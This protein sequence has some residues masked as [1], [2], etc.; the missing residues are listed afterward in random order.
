MFSKN[1]TKFLLFGLFILNLISFTIPIQNPSFLDSNHF[2]ANILKDSGTEQSNSVVYQTVPRLSKSASSNLQKDLI[3]STNIQF[4]KS[5]YYTSGWADTRWKFRKNITISASKVSSDLTNFPVYID[6]FDTDLQQDAQ[7]SGNDIL[8]TNASGDLLDHEIEIYDRVYNSSHSH[9][10]AWVKT[11]LSSS[12]DT[13]ISMYYGN[14]T[15]INQENPSA[16]WDENYEFVLHMNQDP[17]SSDILDSTSNN[18]DFNVE[19]TGSMTSDDLVYGQTGHALTFDGND[20]FIYLP[21]SEGFI[22]PTSAMTFEFWIMFPNGGPG[23]RDF[24]AVPATSGGD[25]RLSF[26]DEFEFHIETTTDTD[27]VTSNQ[28]SFSANTWYHFVGLWN[29]SG[30][31]IHQI[32]LGGSLDGF[33][34][35]PLS[36]T[37]ISWNTL[38][39]GT[40]DDSSDG[41]GGNADGDRFLHATLSEFRLSNTIRSAT[42]IATEFEN[43]N[44]TQTFYSISSEE[45]YSS[46]KEWHYTGLKFRKEIVIDANKVS[47]SGTLTNFP[48]LINLYDTDLHHPNNVQTDGDDILFCDAS[49]T[50]LDHEIELFDQNYDGT[51][52]HLIA[53]VEIPSLSGTD[54]TSI[55]MYFGNEGL[56]SQANSEG[57]W[58][59]NYVGVWHL[60]QDPSGTPPQIEDSTSP[61]TDGTVYGSMTSNDLVSGVI[62]EALNFDGTEDFIDFGNPTEM[63]ITGA[64]TVETWFWS[65]NGDQNEYI[66]GKNGPGPDMR[67]WDLSFDPINNTHGYL[68]FRYDDD[69]VLPHYGEVS[70]VIYEAGQWHHVTGVYYPSTYLR[71]Y[72]DGQLVYD[73]STA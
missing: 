18:F 4:S 24:L 15:A 39:I 63:Q 64:L 72:L 32:Y 33:A 43:Q 7:A 61:S 59:S 53:W 37:H 45:K 46:T 9:L 68:I 35:S 65:D 14:P 54:D 21:I 10:V 58:D 51:Q 31:G 67:C 44:D 57:V 36:G 62:G 20:D 1:M 29:G 56:T 26:Y 6:I 2:F 25:P 3:N 28:T 48:V 13:I 34:G 73:N 38:S 27:T 23:A 50:R 47:G 41:P 5:A 11:N 42:W 16:V 66:I 55:Y 49:G 71:M 69:G 40:E 22:G 60:N 8:F 19:S 12:Q 30:V 17:S 52:A 70:N